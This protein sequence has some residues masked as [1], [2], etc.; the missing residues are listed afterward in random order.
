M[1]SSDSGS[2]YSSVGAG[3]HPTTQKTKTPKKS[4]GFWLNKPLDKILLSLAKNLSVIFVLSFLLPLPF[5][6]LNYDKILIIAF[7]VSNLIIWTDGFLTVYGIRTS[8]TELNPLMA[9]LNK[10]A[11]NKGWLLLSRGIGSAILLYGMIERNLVF[12][13]VMSWIFSIAVCMNSLVLL[14]YLQIKPNRKQS[15]ASKEK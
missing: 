11:G 13:L 4:G 12:L 3:R 5:L 9:L 6:I 14:S 10:F 1:G 8:G 2:V 7:V 15:N